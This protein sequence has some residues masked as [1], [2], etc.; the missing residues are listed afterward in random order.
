M[1]WKDPNLKENTIKGQKT[2]CN[3]H[4]AAEICK[5]TKKTRFFLNF[6]HFW[7]P[8]LRKKAISGGLT[9]PKIAV[10]LSRS[11]WFVPKMRSK[12]SQ[13]EYLPGC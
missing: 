4:W 11:I 9:A 6:R 3:Q 13:I 12:I 8:K 5:N 10:L 1:L 2:L 7:G